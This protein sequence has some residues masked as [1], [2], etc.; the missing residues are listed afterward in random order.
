MCPACLENT[1]IM[2]AGA[3]SVGGILAL[4]IGKLRTLSRAY[5]LALFQKANEIQ[6]PKENLIWQQAKTTSR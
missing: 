3:G 5:A 1:A 6:K 4:Y 2:I